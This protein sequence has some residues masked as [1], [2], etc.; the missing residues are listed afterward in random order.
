MKVKSKKLVSSKKRLEV[1]VKILETK[2]SQAKTES[3]LRSTQK[4]STSKFRSRKASKSGA[5][6]ADDNE[7]FD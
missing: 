7:C 1:K 6:L 2:V 5:G 3:M 4:S